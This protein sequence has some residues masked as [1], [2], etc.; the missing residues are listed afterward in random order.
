M[1]RTDREGDSRLKDGKPNLAAPAPRTRGNRPDLS[2]TSWVPNHGTE[3]LA[4][5]PP[6][7]L[8]N[9]SADLKPEDFTILPWAEALSKQRAADFGKE[10][11]S[12]VAFLCPC[13]RFLQSRFLSRLSNRPRLPPSSLKARADTAGI[14]RLSSVRYNSSRPLEPIVDRRRRRLRSAICRWRM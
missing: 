14:V 13:P 12:H 5:P 7:Y 9:V 2:G 1:V 4:D 10:L 6:K 11:R 8:V 3:G